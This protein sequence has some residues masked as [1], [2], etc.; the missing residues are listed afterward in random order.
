MANVDSKFEVVASPLDVDNG[1]RAR[2]CA[3]TTPLQIHN[4]LLSDLGGRVEA[5][6][7]GL[8]QLPVA[9]PFFCQVLQDVERLLREAVLRRR[10]GK[11][12]DS[13]VDRLG[14]LWV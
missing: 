10:F 2:R 5:V 8:H 12:R 7:P 9:L 11:V 4:V 3:G 13:L 1:T 6:S 14:S